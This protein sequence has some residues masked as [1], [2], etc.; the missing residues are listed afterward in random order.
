MTR[1]AV[2]L[3]ELAMGIER[4]VIQGIENMLDVHRWRY[5]KMLFLVFFTVGEVGYRVIYINKPEKM[6]LEGD[7]SREN[8]ELLLL[9]G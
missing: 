2:G 9:H 6:I 5:R 1:R 4:F 7:W 3:A 8:C